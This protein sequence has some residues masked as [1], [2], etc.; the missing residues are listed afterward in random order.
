MTIRRTY[1]SLDW[2]NSL[3][4]RHWVF[5]FGRR[6]AILRSNEGDKRVLIHGRGGEIN[7][8]N[9]HPDDTLELLNSYGVPYELTKQPDG[10][11]VISERDGSVQHIN[12]EGKT[13]RIW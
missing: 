8:F 5:N 1:Q 2:A 3:F 9:E 4:G 11:Y 6:I 7:S 13:I 12:A 10:T